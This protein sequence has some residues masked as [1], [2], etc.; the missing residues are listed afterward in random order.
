[1]SGLSLAECTAGVR[2]MVVKSGASDPF[3]GVQE[4]DSLGG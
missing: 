2:K 4:K 1:M 3:E